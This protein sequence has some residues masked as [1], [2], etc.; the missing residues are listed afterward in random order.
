ML[1]GV[2]GCK[3]K[4]HLGCRTSMDKATYL[5]ATVHNSKSKSFPLGIKFNMPNAPLCFVEAKIFV[6]AREE[7]LSNVLH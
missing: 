4:G 5:K 1:E 3:T 6:K 2:G 7:M